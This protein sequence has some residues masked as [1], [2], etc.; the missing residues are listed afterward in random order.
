MRLIS[1]LML[2][3][4][5]GTI[6]A[7]APFVE[8]Y[9][10]QGK[11]ALGEQ[12]LLLHLQKKPDDDQARFG[13]GFLQFLR[14]IEHLGQAWYE[15]GVKDNSG[16]PFLRMPVPKNPKPTPMSYLALR[17]VN[18]QLI[19]DLEVA[20]ATLAKVTSDHVQLP[21]QLA[22]I[23]FDFLGDG[24]G[25]TDLLDIMKKL[26]RQD[27]Q[28]L[29]KNPA[30]L[31]KFDR[32]DVAWLRAYCHLLMGMME[33][34]QTIEFENLFNSFMPTWFEKVNL[35]D[36]GDRNFSIVLNREPA[37]M[38]KAREHFLMVCKMNRETWRYIRFEKDDDFEWLPNPK[39]H[40]VIGL[41]VREEMIDQWLEMIGRVEQLLNGELILPNR[42]EA[43]EDDGIDLKKFMTET[44]AE[45]DALELFSGKANLKFLSKGKKISNPDLNRMLN[46]M[47]DSF[48]VGY[49]AWFN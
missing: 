48:G 1:T 45:V 41:P 7:D 28:F 25:L 35:R 42:G 36:R 30:F 9:L 38:A 15:Y 49:S 37:R 34:W 32:A 40:G 8:S 14:A 19:H 47:S 20:E 33:F 44:P 5:T 39:Q 27:F 3:G 10:H 18:D 29:K 2:F 12:A 17:R 11:L 13:L 23:Q 4:L 6:R 16:L 26:M 31:V 22:K 21:L 24:K 46:L 43:D